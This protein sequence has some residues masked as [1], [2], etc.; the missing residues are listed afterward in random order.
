M[1]KPAFP[2][3]R[4]KNRHYRLGAY[5]W[6][7]IRFSALSA[8]FRVLVAYHIEKQQY[9]A[10]LA[11]EKA[12]D[13]TVLAQYEYHGTHP[14][15]HVLASCQEMDQ[16]P[17][18]VMRSPWQTRLPAARGYHRSTAFDVASDDHALDRVAGFFG[19]HRKEG[20]LV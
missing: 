6:R 15:W 11:L 9:R 18:G 19:L 13:L 16:V 7:V 20:R 3:S 12:G 17:S 1:P 8:E 14:G 4:T 10:V 5:R 2:L